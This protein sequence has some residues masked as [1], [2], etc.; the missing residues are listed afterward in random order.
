MQSKAG[1]ITQVIWQ[2]N[3][4]GTLADSRP[5]MWYLEGSW[6]SNNST[7]ANSFASAARALNATATFNNLKEGIEVSLQDNEGSQTLA[8]VIS[9]TDPHTLFLRR[10]NSSLQDGPAESAGNI[11]RL[12]LRKITALLTQMQ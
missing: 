6:V 8:I 12:I 9:L 11:F 10:I 5:D 4:I 1:N 3:V 2:N 7:A